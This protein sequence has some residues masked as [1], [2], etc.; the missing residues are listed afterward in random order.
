[1]CLSARFLIRL[2][3]S[4]DFKTFVFQLCY[5]F[6]TISF[7]CQVC[8]CVCVFSE[9]PPLRSACSQRLNVNLGRF[10][11]SEALKLLRKRLSPG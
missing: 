4:F 7:T 11:F 10:C 8:V 1:M 6:W 5:E 9:A 2:L 3:F